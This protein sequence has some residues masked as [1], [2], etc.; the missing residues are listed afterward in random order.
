[1]TPLRESQLVEAHRAG[2]P[3]ALGELLAGYQKRVYSICYRMIRDD[4]NA[5]DLTQDSLIRIIEKLDT[6]DGRARLSTW[7]I[8]IAMNVCL[9][10]L[11]RERLRRHAPLEAPGSDQIEPRGTEGEPSPASRVEQ[12]EM[13]QI[14]LQA[15]DAID[16]QMRSMIV[17]RDMQGLDYHRIGEVLEI[18]VGTV[19]SRLFRARAALRD[20]ANVEMGARTNSVRS[21]QGAQ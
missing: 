7:V 16:P 19:K 14:L 15:M 13:K 4:Q 18:P 9:S 12:A 11:R 17:L 6:Y 21:G 20:A 10:H 1:M 5:K 3:D 8:R 2:D